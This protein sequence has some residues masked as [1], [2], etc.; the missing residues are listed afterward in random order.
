MVNREV[1]VRRGEKGADEGWGVK[2]KKRG[3]GDGRR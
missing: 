1:G 2:E 3:G